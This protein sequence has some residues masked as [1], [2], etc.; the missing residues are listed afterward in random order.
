MKDQPY[1]PLRLGYTVQRNYYEMHLNR[2]QRPMKDSSPVLNTVMRRVRV[3]HHVRTFAPGVVSVVLLMGA[4]FGLG[5]EV[6]VAKVLENMPSLANIPATLSFFVSAFL[7]TELFVQIL[8][9]VVLA[10]LVWLAREIARALVS[11]PHFA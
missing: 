5:R 8:S 4:L 9:I 1:R 10:A 7:H 6:W 11:H 2:P 3:I